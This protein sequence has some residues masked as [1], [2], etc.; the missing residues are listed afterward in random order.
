VHFEAGVGL[1]AALVLL[2]AKPSQKAMSMSQDEHEAAELRKRV[3]IKDFEDMYKELEAR[4]A[5][6]KNTLKSKS[7]EIYAGVAHSLTGTL[8][9]ASGESDDED[10]DHPCSIRH[11]AP[12]LYVWLMSRLDTRSRMALIGVFFFVECVYWALEDE[13]LNKE[14]ILVLHNITKEASDYLVGVHGSTVD[15]WKRPSLGSL[16]VIVNAFSLVCSLSLSLLIEGTGCFKQIFNLHA[17]WRFALIA[18]GFQLATRAHLMSYVLGLNPATINTVGFAYLPCSMVF[19]YLVFGRS[20]GGTEW[21]SILVMALASMNYVF[22]RFRCSSNETGCAAQK[23]DNHYHDLIPVLL[24]GFSIC[25]SGYSSSVAERIFKHQSI[26]LADQNHSRY[27]IYKVHLDMLGLLFTTMIWLGTT[28]W[29]TYAYGKSPT[30]Q[31]FFGDWTSTDISFAFSIVAHGWLCGLMAKKFSTVT[32]AVVQ[33]VAMLFI[34]EVKDFVTSKFFAG[35]QLTRT[36][37]QF[38]DRGPVSLIM[39]LMVLLAAIVFQTG[40]VDYHRIM[41]LLFQEKKGDKAVSITAISVASRAGTMIGNLLCPDHDKQDGKEGHGMCSPMSLIVILFLAAYVLR[42]TLNS[43]GLRQS[44]GASIIFTIV[45]Q[46]CSTLVSLALI[47]VKSYRQ[48]GNSYLQEIRLAWNFKRILRAIFPTALFYALSMNFGNLAWSPPFSINPPLAMVVGAS[49]LPVS[50]ILSRWILHK[51]YRWLE[52]IA[53]A[54]ISLNTMSYALLDTL[55]KGGAGSSSKEDNPFALFAILLVMLSAT[56]SAAA[57]LTM[58]TYMTAEAGVPFM[59]QKLRVEI[60]QVIVNI[61]LIPVTGFVFGG[62]YAVW[63]A[64]P[65]TMDCNYLGVCGL[66]E[67][68]TFIA[69]QLREAKFFKLLA[70][71]TDFAYNFTNHSGYTTPGFTMYSDLPTTVSVPECFCGSGPFVDWDTPRLWIVVA[72]NSF[73]FYLV[74]LVVVNFGS[75]MRGIFENFGFSILYFVCTPFLAPLLPGS[76]APWKGTLY[77]GALSMCAL[78]YSA[79][80]QIFI[81]ATAELENLAAALKQSKEQ[82]AGEEVSE[83]VQLLRHLTRTEVQSESESGSGSGS[84]SGSESE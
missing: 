59:R 48:E 10:G 56:F 84:G 76:T 50:C 58:Q 80:S 15:S 45:L 23:G 73:F 24:M 1:L 25:V 37:Y 5:E 61:L 13:V 35:W 42:A 22:L 41:D 54:I 38:G 7:T 72:V 52:W 17:I 65:V 12:R 71:N 47:S 67:N 34:Y 64:R 69:N 55:G 20:Y 66:W 28:F 46:C 16:F 2:R 57:G 62:K 39:F 51:Y 60:A 40:R 44:M 9:H 82:F 63:N 14:N 49:Y 79:C 8:V 70:V 21:F 81:Q 68:D 11:R 18:V 74:S 32:R 3:T 31:D 6:Q 33:S 75:V 4:V 83:D 30:A 78:L 77:D 27:Y 26:G 19:G 29:R 53:V 43:W 36:G